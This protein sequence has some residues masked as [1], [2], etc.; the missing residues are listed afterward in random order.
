MSLPGPLQEVA[1]KAELK[2]KPAFNR[3]VLPY[4][5]S[6]AFHNLLTAVVDVHGSAAGK[7]LWERW[8][9]EPEYSET[10]RLQDGGVV[11]LYSSNELDFRKGAPTFNPLRLEEIQKKAVIPNLN[12]VRIIAQAAVKEYRLHESQ[13]ATGNTPSIFSKSEPSQ[14]TSPSEVL[15]FCIDKFRA[16]RLYEKEIDR[17]VQG[18]LSRKMKEPLS[19]KRKTPRKTFKNKDKAKDQIAK[20]LA[21]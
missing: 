9:L 12:T 7:Q 1:E 17:E 13:K 8:C 3:D 21:N 15:D 14:S 18:H 10:R 5:P 4:V 11:R 16:L 20:A 2:Y 6:V 19:E